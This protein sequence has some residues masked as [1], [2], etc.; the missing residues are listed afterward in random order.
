MEKTMKIKNTFLSTKRKK[1]KKLRFI[2]QLFVELNDLYTTIT[3]ELEKLSKESNRVLT[4]EDL[5]V[6]KQ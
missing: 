3:N 2:H 5:S 4:F 6:S 1:A